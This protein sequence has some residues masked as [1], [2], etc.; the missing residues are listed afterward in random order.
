[1][2]RTADVKDVAAILHIRKMLVQEDEF[3]LSEPDEFDRSLDNQRKSLEDVEEQGRGVFLAEIKGQVVAYLI[4][5]RANLNR[6]K[7]TGTL[8]MGVLKGYRNTKLGSRLLVHLMEWANQQNGLEKVCLGV[9]ST[10]ERAMQLYLNHGFEEEGRER[11]QIRWNDGRYA[12]NVLMAR[13]V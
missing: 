11:D 13:F 7:H 3:F 4:F 2:I 10:N 9:L 8:E 12:D 6:M 1:M 5:R